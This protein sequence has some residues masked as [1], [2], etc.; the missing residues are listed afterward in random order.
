MAHKEESKKVKYKT[1][2]LYKKNPIRIPLLFNLTADEINNILTITFQSS[3]EEA[4][5]TIINKNKDTIYL[6]PNTSIYNGK[7][8][9]ISNPNTYPY[10]IEITSPIMDIIGEITTE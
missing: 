10:I 5:I 7:I 2:K 6:E 9:S 1:L 4:N 8:I 3:L